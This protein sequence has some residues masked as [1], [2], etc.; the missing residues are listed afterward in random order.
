MALNV[1]ELFAEINVKDKGTTAVRRFMTTMRD[2]AKKLD[3]DAGGLAKSAGQMGVQFTAA[4]LKAATMAAAMA[5]AAQSAIGLVAALAPAGGIVAALPGAVALGVGAFATLKLALSGVGDAFKAALGDDPKK[6]AESLQGLSPAAQA[7]ARDLHAVKPTLDG[8]KSA[9]QDAFFGPLAGQISAVTSALVGPLREGMSGVASEFGNA[10]VQVAQFLAS[11]Q[12]ASAVSA[13][14]AALRSAVA[15]I[16]PA[17]QPVLAGFRDIA[18]VGAEFSSGLVP[19]ITS[20]AQRFGEFLSNAASSGQALSW[21]QGAMDVFRQLGSVAGDVVGII[22][23][24][25]SAMQTGGSNALGVIGQLLG[26][27]NEFLASAQGQ[28]ILVTIFQSLSQVGQALSPIISALGGALAQIA[29]HI[30]N[31]A[32]ALGPGLAAAVT[33]LGPALAALGPG[34]TTVATMLAQ[35]FASP[36]L[37][38]GLLSLGQGLS[39]ALAAVAP[40]LPVVGQLAGIIGQYLGVALQNLSGMLGP[41]ISALASALQ[42][43]LAS[44]STA[45]TQLGPLIPPIAAAFGQVLGSVVQQLLP[46]I[47]NLV[48]ALLNDLVP[49]MVQLMQ[50][51]IP[52]LPVLTDLGVLFVQTLVPAMMPWVSLLGEIGKAFAAFGQQVGTV[53]A[54]IKPFLDGLVSA[55]TSMY[56]TLVGH[57]VIPDMVNGIGKWIGTTLIGFF[58]ELPGKIASA[59][60]DIG[61][62]MAEIGRNIVSGVWNGIQG[63]A[64]SF[65]NQVKGFFSNIVDSVKGALGINSPS[66][67]FAEIG[68]FMMRGLSVGVDKTAGLVVTSLNKVASLAAKTAMP[69]LSMPGVTVPDG[70]GGG[71]AFSRTVVNVTN[72]YPQAEPTSVSVNKSLQYVGAIGVI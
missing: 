5:S 66:K 44:I 51:V 50:S 9:V 69:D 36:E 63:M 4:A 62:R 6:F 41:V 2:A 17:I 68:H 56:N 39:A 14:F 72:H 30:A 33:A 19:G 35:A 31:I 28:Q 64:S 48:P 16:Q 12:T 23:S 15:A 20:A 53:V 47:L 45:L 71:R 38:A 65:Y 7:A 61:S 37:Q 46:P 22:K 26:K 34:L 3:I 54:A 8:L 29:P 49:A 11:A 27:V 55:F 21:M 43:A 10:G 70:L 32:T 58:R 52:L 57:S 42:P 60:G 1:G 67:V 18:V 25:F 24:V 59:V 40:L 13:I